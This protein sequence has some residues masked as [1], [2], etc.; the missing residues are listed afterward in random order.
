MGVLGMT[1]CISGT[2]PTFITGIFALDLSGTCL[3]APKV[4][5]H[6]ASAVSAE[7]R[8]NFYLQ[9]NSLTTL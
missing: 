1:G 5:L 8:F 3:G 2:T 4:C 6:T 9:L 7:N